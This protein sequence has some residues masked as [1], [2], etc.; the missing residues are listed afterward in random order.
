MKV[1]YLSTIWRCIWDVQ[2]LLHLLSSILDVICQPHALTALHPRQNTDTHWTGV[3][4]GPKTVWMFWRRE[5]YLV[6]AGNWTEDRLAWLRLCN[7]LTK[8]NFTLTYS[9]QQSPSWKT[10]WFWRNSPH[11]M[12][13]ESSSPYSKT[14]ATCPYPQPTPSSPHNPFP[15]PEDPS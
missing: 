12:E 9:M 4:V 14:P 8:S 5:E 10:N 3:W 13:H 2:V 1:K 11:F 15:L 7:L 6:P